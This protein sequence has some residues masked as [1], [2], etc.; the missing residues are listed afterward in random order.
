[1]Q[2]VEDA[3]FDNC[4]ND[5]TEAKRLLNEALGDDGDLMRAAF[6]ER[7]WEIMLMRRVNAASAR[8]KGQVPVSGYIRSKP[9]VSALG[10]VGGRDQAL[11]EAQSDRVSPPATGPTE[12][13]R[14]A[15]KTVNKRLA[16]SLLTA[17]SVDGVP[18]RFCTKGRVL[19][20]AVGDHAMALFKRGL[21][22]GLPTDDCV[23]GDY[24]DDD[25]AKQAMKAALLQ[26]KE[27][28]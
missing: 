8:A 22:A 25:D 3:A 6:T 7:E 14:Q 19:E 18:I 13:Q 21:V 2:E 24:L 27:A 16:N 1:M 4:N 9:G 20:S 10:E 15:T 12:Q 17:T 23:V 28:I 5:Y 26:A 11:N